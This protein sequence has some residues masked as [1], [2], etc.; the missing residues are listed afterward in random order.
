MYEYID[1]ILRL[2]PDAEFN[3]FNGKI[4]DWMDERK[5]PTEEEIQAEINNG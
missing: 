2:V 1:A 3:I 4:S 5:Q